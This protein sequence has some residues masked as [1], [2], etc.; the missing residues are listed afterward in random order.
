MKGEKRDRQTAKQSRQPLGKLK[1]RK[2]EEEK[3][4]GG[5]FKIYNN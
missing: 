5:G 3:K 2:G 1:I 4:G